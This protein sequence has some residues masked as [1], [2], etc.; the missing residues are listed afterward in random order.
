MDPE[1]SPTAL[2]YLFDVGGI[3]VINN[4]D[5]CICEEL[6]ENVFW[7]FSPCAVEAL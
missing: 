3:V 2:W 1:A 7:G 4:I 5:L 6:I